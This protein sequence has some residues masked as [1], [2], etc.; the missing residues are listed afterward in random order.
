MTAKLFDRAEEGG[1]FRP[2]VL[3]TTIHPPARPTAGK[4]RQQNRIAIFKRLG[5]G[6]P[7]CGGQSAPTTDH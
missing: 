5:D 3:K 2:W 4:I 1:I 7:V 6:L